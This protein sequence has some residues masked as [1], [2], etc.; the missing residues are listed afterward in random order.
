[1]E[2]IYLISG[3]LLAGLVVGLAGWL[4]AALRYQREA[5]RLRETLARLESDLESERRGAAEKL[6]LLQEAE[7]KLREAFQALSA[8]ALRQNNQ[9]FLELAK[10]SLGE[11]HRAATGD[12]ESRQK[13]IGDL[14]RPVQETLKQVDAHLHETE[15]ARVGAYSTLTEQVR[16]M[17]AA[18]QQLQSETGNLVKALRAPQV[19]GRWGE[20]QLRRVVEMAGMLDHCDFHEQPTAE[21]DEGRLRPDLVVRLPGGKN[22]IVDAKAP[23]GA[24]LEALEAT[25]DAVREARLKD[26]ARQ[27]REHVTKLGSKTYRDQFQPS[28]EFVVL[29]LPGETFFSAALQH[30]PALI[31][32]GVDRWVIP[33]SPTTLISL[34]RAVAYG[35]QQEKV[36][37]NAQVIGEL[38]KT[39]YERVRVMADHFED[40]RKG[41]NQTIAAYNKAVGSMETRVLVTARRF[42]DLGVGSA[43]EIPA[44]EVLDR[45][46]RAIQAAER[47]SASEVEPEGEEHEVLDR[48][49]IGEGA[50][51]TP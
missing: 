6:A 32:Y 13:A 40:L 27:V 9:S 44:V 47:T 15:K 50:D 46:P 21:G 31:E 49:S 34:L 26:H 5:G 22:V 16:S 24:Y 12:L 4:L 30:D 17:A 11:F 28:P 45:V 23:L 51:T 41:L 29:F 37:A 25:D 14:V 1:M 10:A 36:A 43:A 42:K 18:Q 8:E 39:L 35:W 19:R 33:A 48:S 3:L 38:G 2:S 7:A 20:I